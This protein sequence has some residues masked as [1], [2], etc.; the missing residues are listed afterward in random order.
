M[1]PTANRNK[2]CFKSE[3]EHLFTQLDPEPISV[4]SM[5]NPIHK[6]VDLGTRL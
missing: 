4:T 1:L 2:G 3:Q 6:V 5:I